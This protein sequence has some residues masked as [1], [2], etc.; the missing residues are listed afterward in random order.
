MTRAG[1]AD[2]LSTS[3]TPA[4]R[5]PRWPLRVGIVA[6]A[7]IALA[8][9]MVAA[10]PAAAPSK[11]AESAV[12]SKQTSVDNATPAR[13]LKAPTDSHTFWTLGLTA[14]IAAAGSAGEAGKP[15]PEPP[16]P[17]PAPTTTTTAPPA[18]P[19]TAAPAPAP[20]PTPAVSNG[21]TWDRLA[22]CEAGGNWAIDTGNGFYGGLQFSASSWHAVGGSGLPNQA[23]RETQIAMG[24]RLRS[25]Q[26]WGAW[27]SCSAQL[28]LR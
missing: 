8:A 22:Q 25:A 19:V 24:E 26:G 28:G 21:G 17:T 15:L 27:P 12:T 14:T 5:A 3:G 1:G 16:A 13:A 23:S 10:E 6:L 11:P 7:G 4:G 18:P 20:S 9:P 2:P